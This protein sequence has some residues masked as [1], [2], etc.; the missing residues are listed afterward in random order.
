MIICSSCHFENP[1][2]HRY[3]QQC[4]GALPDIIEMNEEGS[5]NEHN[6]LQTPETKTS[7]PTTNPT[8]NSMADAVANGMMPNEEMGVLTVGGDRLPLGQNLAHTRLAII[9]AL[10]SWWSL[11]TQPLY[12]DQSHRYQLLADIDPDKLTHH[13]P[14]DRTPD[15][16]VTLL[17]RYAD[18]LLQGLTES[19]P[20]EVVQSDDPDNNTFNHHDLASDTPSQGIPAT[21]WNSTNVSASDPQSSDGNRGAIAPEPLPQPD[22]ETT[23]TSTAPVHPL[24]QGPT[25]DSIV[26]IHLTLQDQ[27]YPSFPPVLDALGD[28]IVILENRSV[29]LPLP[30]AIAQADIVLP[31]ILHWLHEMTELW[32]IL[33]QHRCC[34]SLLTPDNIRVDEDQILCLRRLYLDHREAR[35]Q[36]ADLGELW[37]HLRKC[38]SLP[39]PDSLE[40]IHQD[41]C[42][43]TIT[44]T[45]TLRHRLEFVADKIYQ[46][47]VTAAD[48]P[49]IAAEEDWSTVE[50]P[51]DLS[52]FADKIRNT[53]MDPSSPMQDQTA[54]DG[55]T[56][57]QAHPSTGSEIPTMGLAKKRLT[58]SD[59]P[60]IVLPMQL[61][62]L[63]HVGSTNNGIQRDHNEDFFVIETHTSNVET[64][65]ERRCHAK[66]L[67]I[68]CDGM[69]GHSAGEIASAL[70]GETLQAYFRE[71]WRDQLPD[72]DTIQ[73]GIV[74]TNQVIYEQNQ[75]DHSE[76]FR[77]MGTTLVTLLVQDTKV[78][79]A[80]VG[81]S[82]IYRFTRRQG[83][84]QLTLDHEVGQREISRGVDPSVAYARPDAQQLTQALGPRDQDFIRPDINFWEMNEDSLFIL[85]SDGLTDNDLLEDYCNSH[86]EPLISGTANLDEGAYNLIDLANQVNGHDNITVILVRV[87]LRPKLS[88]IGR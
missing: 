74:Q 88:L 63:T 81:D 1:S 46:E 9:T 43:C 14:S 61:H 8:A 33:A 20:V 6:P 72:T 5:V 3:C 12:L 53:D 44:D 24:E 87:K 77:R 50:P 21:A 22:V 78:A 36:M 15:I 23:T 34:A 55:L 30:D 54:P 58:L 16:E 4:G 39:W 11:P 83:L 40:Q 52:N 67:Y 45:D 62:T 18:N 28:D 66:G 10:P 25:H 42:T 26:Q 48:D 64:P 38:S 60:T 82:R 76:G 51:A 31:Q 7:S 70:A 80:H 13:G 37:H 71:H 32:E 57:A 35:P 17:D 59:D 84:E 29:L 27:L 41:L 73:Q 56:S 49:T 86:I 65:T 68:L 69:G 75:A 19:D 47:T 2:H 85:G 79:I